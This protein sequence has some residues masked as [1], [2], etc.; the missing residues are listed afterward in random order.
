[1][2]AGERKS[3]VS[4][5]VAARPKIRRKKHSSAVGISR[6]AAGF[7]NFRS[8]EKSSAAKANTIGHPLAG[9]K[10]HFETNYGFIYDMDRPEGIAANTQRTAKPVLSAVSERIGCGVQTKRST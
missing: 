8:A 3:T 9:G 2:E 10:S 7:A 1:M 5:A 6:W 4:M